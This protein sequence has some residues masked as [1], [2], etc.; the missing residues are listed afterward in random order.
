MPSNSTIPLSTLK[1]AGLFPN[2]TFRVEL[3][4][5]LT[6]GLPIAIAQIGGMLSGVISTSFL[7]ELGALPVAAMGA[8]NPVF[9]IVALIGIGALSMTSPLVAAAQ[10]RGDEGEVKRLLYASTILAVLLAVVQIIILLFIGQNFHLLG[11]TPEVAAAALPFL[12]LMIPVLLPLLL[13]S[14]FIFFTDGLSK[15]RIGMMFSLVALALNVLLCWLLVFGK[16]G[17]PKLGLPGVALSMLL[18]EILQVIAMWW[19]LRRDPFFQSFFAV[20]ISHVEVLTKLREYASLALPVGLQ[21]L[22]EYPAYTLGAI[23]I[24]NLGKY[25]LAGHQIAITLASSTF[26]ILMAIGAAASIRVG[27]AMGTRNGLQIQRSGVVGMA[28]AVGFVMIP[29]LL[30]NIMPEPI[31]RL[32]IDDENV[33]PIATSLLMIAGFFQ[34]SDAVQS[35]GISLLRGLEDTFM[36][37]VISFVCYWLIGVPLGYWFTF[38]LGWGAIGVWYSFLIGLSTQAVCFSVRFWQLSNKMRLSE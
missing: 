18:T 8:A 20:P 5:I 17:F 6:L 24:G 25:P 16:F 36:P 12:W 32:F 3:K 34:I 31:V 27:Q 38:H 37:S 11:Y 10:E 9:W 13:F 4:E 19:Y 21:A 28:L 33:L 23:W 29:L 15:T 2:N 22:I 26:V 1:P 30:F 14:N 7:G 35:V